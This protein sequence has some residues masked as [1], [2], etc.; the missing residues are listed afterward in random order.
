MAKHTGYASGGNEPPG[1]GLLLTPGPLTTD[2]RTRAAMM[3]DWGSR[4]RDFIEL[5]ARVRRRLADLCNLGDDYACV[6][7]QGS[8]T[9]AVE[10]MIA[11]LVPAGGRLVVAVNGAYG[12]RIATI[13]RRLG[14]QVETADSP[15]HLPTDL[16]RLAQVLDRAPGASHLAVVHCETTSG[17]LNPLAEVAAL[18]R[19]RNIRLLVDA[20]SSFGALELDGAALGLEAVAASANKCLEGVPGVAFVIARRD[21][22]AAAAGNCASLSLDLH[23][24]WGALEAN[25]QWRF[26]PPTHV[27]AALDCA[28]DQLDGEGGPAARRVRYRQNCAALVAGMRRLGFETLLDDRDQ[29]PIIVTFHLPADPGFSFERFYDALHRRGVVIYPGKVTAA[30]TFRIGC[31]GAIGQAAI[32]TALA[33]V[34]DALAELGIA[35]GAPA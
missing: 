7:I 30:A 17:V 20:M 18:A 5:T 33:A 23:D 6:P 11:T 22:L 12:Q 31:I 8:G 1:P 34:E 27:I 4:D 19:E 16:A 2:P 35:S 26:T 21:A 9:F 24:Q 14:R 32:E 13:A 28:L 10:A 3:R 25:G 29:A 15:E